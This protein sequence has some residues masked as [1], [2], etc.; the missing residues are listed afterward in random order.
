MFIGSLMG[1][2]ASLLAG[3][4]LGAVSPAHGPML[5]LYVSRPLGARTSSIYGL[6]LDQNSTASTTTHPTGSYDPSA[7]RPLIDLQLRN[8]QLRNLQLT[9]PADLRVEFG[10][11]VSWDLQR[12]VFELSGN[13]APKPMEF[14]AQSH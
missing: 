5:M 14:V 13:H 4:P 6:R 8:L 12:R 9:R 11:R 1:C 7:Q 10:Q 2:T 3:E